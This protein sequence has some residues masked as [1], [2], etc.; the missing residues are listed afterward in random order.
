L[1]ADYSTLLPLADNPQA[2]VDELNLLLAANQIDSSNIANIKNAIAS[3]PSKN[4]RDRSQRIYAAL[5]L[6]LAAPEFIVLK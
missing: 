2:L 5:T 6:V 4:D 3:M 1:R